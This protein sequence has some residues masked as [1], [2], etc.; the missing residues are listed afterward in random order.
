MYNIDSIRPGLEYIEANLQTDINAAELAGAAGYSVWH[1]CELFRKVTGMSVARYVLK[2][3]LDRALA[4]IFGG[5]SAVDAALWYG[6]DTYAGF[7]K[8]FVKMYGCSPK[9]YLSIYGSHQSQTEVAFMFSKQQLTAVLANWDLQENT[10]IRDIYIQNGAKVAGNVWNVGTEYILKTGERSQILRNLEIAKA[11]AAQGF[12]AA[13]PVLTKTGAEYAGGEN[14]FVLTQ[15]I[16][17]E[18]LQNS[19]RFGE[20]CEKYGEKYGAAIAKLHNAIANIES[21]IEADEV[22]LL[23]HVKDWA[24]P[25]VRKQNEQWKM[26]LTAEFF[27]DYIENF[28]ELYPQL[29]KQLIHRDPNPGNI[30]FSNGEITGFI[31]FDL[32]ER[33]IRLWDICYCAT[34]LLSE[35]RESEKNYDLWFTILGGILHGYDS[36]NALTDA[37][38]R[39]IYYVICSIM[40]IC[41]AYF[42]SVPEYSALA[43]TNREMLAFIVQNKGRIS[44]VI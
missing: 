35:W 2:R 32:A 1:Y 21:E 44:E 8:A 33:N 29:P 13:V 30:L 18:P 7:Y 19:E 31:D 17:G 5:M 16:D 38:K 23:Q 25:E 41:V 15:R 3:R 43:K 26:G 10:V 9:K 12:A 28:G 24:L 34:G 37:E 40:L 11:L 22:N 6:F 42:E 20:N 4:D 27:S 39:A 14:I 36:E